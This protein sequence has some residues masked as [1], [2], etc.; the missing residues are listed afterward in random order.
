M[1]KSSLSKTRRDDNSSCTTLSRMNGYGL[2]SHYNKLSPCQSSPK[3]SIV[4]SDSSSRNPS[5]SNVS[6]IH[7]PKY[8]ITNQITPENCT[9]QT[10]SSIKKNRCCKSP[11]TSVDGFS[12][13]SPMVES[14]V[15]KEI[16]CSNPCVDKRI[17]FVSFD[18]SRAGKSSGLRMPS[19]KIDFF[20]MDNFMAHVEN[21]DN[22]LHSGAVSKT[23]GGQILNDVR[24]K[25][26]CTWNIKSTISGAVSKVDEDKDCLKSEKMVNVRA[27]AH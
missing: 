8:R 13:A 24:N 1:E 11:S 7:P 14:I 2:F 23:Q 15:Y 12:L 26:T 9:Y 3:V 4:K 22:N 25:M 17:D 16:I 20:D 19:P 27:R 10:H 18:T 21:R 5:A 6:V